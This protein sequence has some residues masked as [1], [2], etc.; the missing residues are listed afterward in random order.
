MPCAFITGITGQDG[1][2]LAELLLSKGYAV[3]GLVRSLERAATA[4]HLSRIRGQATLHAGSLQDPA[5]LAG[6]LRAIQPTE[7]YHF[8]AQPH[9]PRSWINPADTLLINSVGTA[10]LLEACRQCP[11]VP[12]FFY[13]STCQ[14]FGNPEQMPQD[15]TTPVNPVNPYGVSKAAA[16][17]LVQLARENQGLFAVNGILYN[18]ESPRRGPEFVTGKI[19]H[20]AAAIKQGRQQVLKLGD[21]DARRDWG[22]AR[23]FVEGFWRS[24]QADQ[25]DDYIF[26]TG[27]LHSVR[28]VLDAAFGAVGLDWKQHVETDPSLVRKTDPNRFL[29]NPARAGTRLDWHPVNR[30]PRLIEE[31]TLSALTP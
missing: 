10:M 28:D 19:C 25:P 17:R 5:M 20:A 11:Q 24:L 12:R 22:D 26:A 27:R 31:M 16:T 7:V 2:Y 1:S 30:L 15:E 8:A 6:L 29:G 23:E 9:I 14:V 4:P 13:A 18:H 3:H 21:L